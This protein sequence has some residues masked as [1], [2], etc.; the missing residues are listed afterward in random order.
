M[1]KMRILHMTPPIV[2]N[3]VYRYIFNNWEY[4]EHNKCEF[5]FL[6]QAPDELMKT[7]EWR[8]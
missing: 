6:I 4:M 5:S 8:N 3:G 2:N 7:Y 1:D